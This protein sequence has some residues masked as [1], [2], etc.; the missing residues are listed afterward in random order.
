MAWP[1][2]ACEGTGRPGLMRGYLS[3]LD[4]TE[5]K[6]ARHLPLRTNIGFGQ[7]LPIRPDAHL[8]INFPK[9]AAAAL[10]RYSPRNRLNA[11]GFSLA[12]R[13]RTQAAPRLPRPALVCLPPRSPVREHRSV[14]HHNQR[15]RPSRLQ[16]SIAPR[17]LLTI[18][19]E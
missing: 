5:S 3:I 13:L 19:Y 10:R 16:H 11:A 8:N 17:H 9:T 7:T 6:P 2:G 15:S 12:T 18:L 14:K 1:S 4:M